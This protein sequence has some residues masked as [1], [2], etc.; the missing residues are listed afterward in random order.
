MSLQDPSL[1]VLSFLKG[2]STGVIIPELLDWARTLGIDR[3]LNVARVL[4]S[5]GLARLDE[6]HDGVPTRLK[7]TNKAWQ[8]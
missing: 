4:V 5:E 1:E 6:G 7:A 2:S 3:P 8:Q